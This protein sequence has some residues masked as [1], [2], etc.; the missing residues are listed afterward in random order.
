[1]RSG[2]PLVNEIKSQLLCALREDLPEQPYPGIEATSVAVPKTSLERRR[3]AVDLIA[4]I[5]P[6]SARFKST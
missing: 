2:A 3:Q 1:M 6:F 5:Q 4:P